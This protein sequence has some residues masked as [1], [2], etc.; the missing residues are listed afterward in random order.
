MTCRLI[1]IV[2][3]AL[4]AG[5]SRL[6][7]TPGT[8]APGPAPGVEASPAA[9]PTDAPQGTLFIVGGGRQPVALMRRFV[10]LAGGPGHARILVLP[11]ASDDAEAAGEWQAEELRT[12]GARARSLVLTREEAKDPVSA[13]HFEGVTGIWFTGGLQSRLAGVVRGTP[14]E[15]AIHERYRA[16]AVVGGTSAGAAVMTTPMITGDELRPG[17]TRPARDDDD[18]FRTVDRGNVMTAP[19]FDLLPGAIVDQHFIRRKRHNRLISLVLEHPQRIG[20]GID[21]STALEVRPDGRWDVLG[22][23]VVVIYD[24]RHAAVTV[25]GATAL[26]VRELRLHLLPAGSSY[27][28]R[29]GEA[30]LPRLKPTE[31]QP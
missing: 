8:P 11:M 24:A 12:L 21:E 23:S 28:P 25:P 15:A 30:E 6:P 29:T 22:E 14:V 7:S 19:G 2:L 10:E 1:A 20:V 5:C 18:A 3:A 9:H 13:R 16:G 17:S 4:A 26:G 27:D 31:F